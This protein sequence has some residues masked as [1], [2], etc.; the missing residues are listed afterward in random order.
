MYI[1]GTVLRHGSE[2]QKQ[3]Y[4]PKI[5]SGELRL[6]MGCRYFWSIYVRTSATASRSAPSRR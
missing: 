5:A 4:L 2:Q 3:R 1:M 6:P